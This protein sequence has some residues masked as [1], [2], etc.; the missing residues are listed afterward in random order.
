MSLFLMSNINISKISDGSYLVN[1]DD[2]R[3]MNLLVDNLRK[4]GIVIREIVLQKTSLEDMFI[5]LI[6]EAEGEA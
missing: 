3:T 1:V 6:K 2:V 5:D 4:D